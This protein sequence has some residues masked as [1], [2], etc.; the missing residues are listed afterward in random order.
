MV[1]IIDN[2]DS[3]VFNIVQYVAALG[4]RVELVRNDA[5]SIAQISA[6]KPRK[7]IVS[8]GPGNPDSAGI[9][10]PLIEHFKGR[11]PIL[12]VCLGHQCI[13]QA[14]GAKIVAAKRIMHGKTSVI[15]HSGSGLFSNL[16]PSFKVAR[17]HSLAVDRPSLPPELK[18]SAWASAGADEQ[19]IMAI[20]HHNYPIYG[21]QFHPESILSEHG[22]QLLSNFLH[23]T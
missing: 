22:K 3:F 5:L 18:I 19:Q 7:I 8:P 11:L 6:K 17:Y 23:E 10:M 14:F 2:Y 15:N 4:S 12:G 21:L 9:S 13:A 1:L 16:P 20:E